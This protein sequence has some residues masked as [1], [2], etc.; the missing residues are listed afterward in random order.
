MEGGRDG[1]ERQRQGVKQMLQHQE[2]GVMQWKGE[3]G[4]MSAESEDGLMKHPV[5]C[6]TCGCRT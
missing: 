2:E 5:V 4:K 3:R 1:V 6:I